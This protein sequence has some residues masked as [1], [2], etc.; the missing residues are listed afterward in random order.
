MYMGDCILLK[1]K[2]DTRASGQE[3]TYLLAISLIR[4][5]RLREKE[6]PPTTDIFRI[7]LMPKSSHGYSGALNNSM[8]LFA[9]LYGKLKAN[10]SYSL[11]SMKP[12]PR[13]FSVPFLSVRRCQ[14]DTRSCQISA[15]ER[16]Y[17]IG[18]I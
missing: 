7:G 6:T 8:G 2:G 10:R 13:L 5:K 18:C 12:L 16:F 17:K 4:G 9:H 11:I 14:V 15:Y 1:M 3:G